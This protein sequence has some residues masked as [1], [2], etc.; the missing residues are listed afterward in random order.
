MFLVGQSGMISHLKFFPPESDIYKVLLK[1]PVECN[2]GPWLVID[3]VWVSSCVPIPYS[4]MICFLALS[5]YKRSI[6][7]ET[8]GGKNLFLPFL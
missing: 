6:L 7:L 1:D 2:E 3:L 8:P 4:L 5:S